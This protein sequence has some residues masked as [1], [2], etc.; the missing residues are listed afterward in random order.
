MLCLGII[1][2]ITIPLLVSCFSTIV[3]D[4]VFFVICEWWVC[5]CVSCFFTLFFSSSLFFYLLCFILVCFLLTCLFSRKREKNLRL[6][7]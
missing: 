1:T 6:E 5:V 7:G 3:S 4:F 2:I